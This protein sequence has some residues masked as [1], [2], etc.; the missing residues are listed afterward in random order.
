MIIDYIT[1]QLSLVYGGCTVTHHEGYW[2]NA[3]RFVDQEH[4]VT[5]SC[6]TGY[7]H[8]PDCFVYQAEKLKEMGEESV[9]ITRQEI[10]ADFE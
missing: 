9:L 10:K 3:D 6:I 4:V 8:R 7:T 2:M 1:N 5:I